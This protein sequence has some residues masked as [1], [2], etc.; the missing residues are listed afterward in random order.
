MSWLLEIII[1]SLDSK[2][3]SEAVLHFALSSSQQKVELLRNLKKLINKPTDNNIDPAARTEK[4][5]LFLSV[6]RPHLCLI[7]LS[8]GES[9]MYVSRQLS[10]TPTQKLNSFPENRKLV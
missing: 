1:N 5:L 10:G 2:G 7:M 4:G 3:L 9:K 6:K 8:I